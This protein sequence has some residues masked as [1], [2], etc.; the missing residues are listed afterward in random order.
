MNDREFIFM[1]FTDWYQNCCD[2]DEDRITADR[3]LADIISNYNYIEYK[4]GK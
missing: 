1:V 4:K 3:I 2:D